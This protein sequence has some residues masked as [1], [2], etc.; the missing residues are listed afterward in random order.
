LLLTK[1]SLLEIDIMAFV[2]IDLWCICLDAEIQSGISQ[3]WHDGHVVEIGIGARRVVKVAVKSVFLV[4]RKLS[5]G[6]WISV[7]FTDRVPILKK[8]MFKSNMIVLVVVCMSVSELTKNQQL[9]RDQY[10][11]GELQDQLPRSLSPKKKV[12]FCFC[13]ELSFS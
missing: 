2:S 9:C 7:D 11:F 3:R 4:Q 6:W 13:L 8:Q 12:F 1:I 5:R 10:D